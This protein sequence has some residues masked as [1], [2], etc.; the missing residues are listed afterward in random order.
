MIR[1]G[2]FTF[3]SLAQAF[4]STPFDNKSVLFFSFLSFEKCISVSAF[5]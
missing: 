1:T 4:F 5:M 3:V 2:E